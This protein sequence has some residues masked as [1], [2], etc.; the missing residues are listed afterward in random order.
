M[1][2]FTKVDFT[3][4][5]LMDAIALGT[6]GLPDL[7][8]PFVWKNTKVRNL[9]D[10]MYRGFPVG[11]FLF[12]E[13][14]AVEGSRAIGTDGKQKIPNMLIVDGQQRL[15]SLYAVIRGVPVVR[16]NYQ[17]ELIE[18]AFNPLLE[19]F[20][21]LDAAIQ[22]DKSYIPNISVIWSKNA[23]LFDLVDRYLVDL[24]GVREVS[25]DDT[26][27]VRKAFSRLQN[28]LSF[29]FTTLALSAAIDEEQVSEIFV[30]INSAGKSLNQADFILTL[31]SVFWDEG[32]LQ[33]EEF[34]RF[35]RT[36]G[37]GPSPFNHFIEPG[38]DQLLRVSVGVGFRRARLQYVY[39]ILRGKDLETGEFSAERRESQFELLKKAQARV[40]N[41]TYW[42]DFLKAILQA[43][44]RSGQ[45][46]SSENNLLFAY[47]LYLLGRT[48][49]G[50]DEFAL[51]GLIARWFFMT[52][53][54]A[55]YSSSPESKDGV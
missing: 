51:R 44:F 30:R 3:M 14:A 16:D 15:T 47:I 23:D 12:W 31:M 22:K 34:C 52:A 26:R 38:P 6:V 42:H 11:Y 21:V 53:L 45:V 41:L 7:Q 33:L 4:G 48:E 2:V 55:R 29:P 20:E 32:R 50:V 13:N 1:T 18:I 24:K 35:S 36:P 49:Y 39:S 54:T 27:V 40:I 37:K 28:L 5:A 10:S 43:G 19:Q 17:S 46:I 9:F 8:R 25:D